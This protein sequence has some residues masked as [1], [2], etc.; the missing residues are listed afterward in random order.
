MA[1]MKNRQPQNCHGQC[2]HKSKI[3]N[4]MSATYH[5]VGPSVRELSKM[6]EIQMLESSTFDTE[7]GWTTL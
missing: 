5:H 1:H 7:K 2:H 3:Q 6:T 4:I